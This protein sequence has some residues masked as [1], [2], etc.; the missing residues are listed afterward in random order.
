MKIDVIKFFFNTFNCKHEKY[1]R[2]FFFYTSSSSHYISC[3]HYFSHKVFLFNMHD[4]GQLPNSIMA[5]LLVFFLFL[6]QREC[7]CLYANT[8]IIIK[9]TV[10]SNFKLILFWLNLC[11]THACLPAC[12]HAQRLRIGIVLNVNHVGK[13]KSGKFY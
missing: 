2:F 7:V 10:K 8:R 5:L 4:L 6:W 12:L 9:M 13:G 1:L 11:T 3:I